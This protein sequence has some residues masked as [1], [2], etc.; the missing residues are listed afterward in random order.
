MKRLLLLTAC[1]ILAS[2]AA[3]AQDLLADANKDGKVTETEY[4]ASRRTFLMRADTN[5]DG[6]ISRDEWTRGALEEREALEGRGVPH[7]DI[8]GRSNWFDIID[9]NKDGFVTPAEIDK[10]SATHFA[11][12][13]LNHDGVVT[14]EEAATL[15]KLAQKRIN[16]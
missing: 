10:A 5:H 9:A 11:Q 1:A 7:A 16:K 15:N 12:L 8:V 3:V 14:R 13:D 6:K 4:A 2:P